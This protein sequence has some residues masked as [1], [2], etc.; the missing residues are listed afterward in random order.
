MLSQKQKPDV[1]IVVDNSSTPAYDW[2]ISQDLPMVQYERIHGTHPIGFLRNRCIELA[3][4]AGAEYIV[5]W[6]DDDYYPPTRIS[7][8]VGALNAN[9]DMDI[10]GSSRMF[11]LLVRENV[12]MET[13]PHGSNHATAA[14]WTVRRKYAESHRFLDEKARGEEVGF[15]NGWT[16]KMFQ[17]PA[18]DTIVVMGH[19]RNTVDKSD[20]L[21]NPQK[22]KSKIVNSDNGKMLLRARWPV[23][24]D[25]FQATF[26]ASR[27]DRLPENTPMVPSPSAEYLIPHIV[28]TEESA[29]RRA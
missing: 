14:T 15:T 10:A 9:P 23:S 8:G 18:E 20:I 29:E 4:K 22:Y 3:L 16:A 13:G 11:L 25:L 27:C 12:M 24:W 19:G 1:W 5:F 7:S 6:D 2:S 26:V 28:G 17:V 21:A